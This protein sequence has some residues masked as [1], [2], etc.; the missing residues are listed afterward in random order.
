MNILVYLLPIAL[1]LGLTGL[2]AFVWAL[3]NGQYDDIDGASLRI[4]SDDDLPG[5]DVDLNQGR[6][7]LGG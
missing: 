7:A 6:K 3:R 1:A 4:L 2:F 5:G